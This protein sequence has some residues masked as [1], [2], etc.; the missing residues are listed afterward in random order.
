ME[1]VIR[2]FCGFCRV[3]NASC[4]LPT[5]LLGPVPRMST[6]RLTSVPGEPVQPESTETAMPSFQAAVETEMT[7]IGSGP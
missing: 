1:P 7:L 4:P 6:I 5:V 2:R 3:L